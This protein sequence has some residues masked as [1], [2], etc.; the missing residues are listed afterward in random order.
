MGDAVGVFLGYGFASDGY[1]EGGDAA[2]GYGFAVEQLLVVGGGIDGVAMG[3]GPWTGAADRVCF[4][5]HEER[6][7]GVTS[8]AV[9]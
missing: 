5:R 2:P 1:V 3:H 4:L 6:A 8:S 7:M 9:P